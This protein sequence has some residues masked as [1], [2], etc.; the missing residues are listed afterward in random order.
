MVELLVTLTLLAL[1]ASVAVPLGQLTAQRNREME[2]RIDLRDLR[3]A[4]DA[5]K[6]AYDEGQIEKKV[7]E[8]GYPPTL[9]TLVQGVDDSKSL[10]SRKKI[11]FLRRIPRDPMCN[12]P[13][14]PPQETWNLRSYASPP[15]AP[16]AGKDVFDVASRSKE[17]A[18][19]G[20]HYNTW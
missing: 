14:T 4:I 18:L 5:Y 9:E 8:S 16:R 13:D 15:D 20:T 19:D 12:C 11:Y 10:E 17:E 7:G 1:L 2:L 6:R 3:R